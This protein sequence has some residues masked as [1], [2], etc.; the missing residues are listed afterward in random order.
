MSYIGP[1]SR[2]AR[3]RQGDLL[4]AQAYAFAIACLFILGSFGSFFLGRAFESAG[5]AARQDAFVTSLPETMLCFDG[6]GHPFS[7]LSDIG[8]GWQNCERVKYIRPE[9]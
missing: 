5:R 7:A 4:T 3:R 2:S 6:A 8:P 9:R 1:I